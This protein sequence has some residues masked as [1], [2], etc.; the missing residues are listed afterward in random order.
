MDAHSST[1]RQ[2]GFGRTAKTAA[3]VAIFTGVT[4]LG[5][6]AGA[7]PPEPGRASCM[8]YEASAV[9]PPGTSDEAP[10]G[11]PNVLADVDEFFVSPN[12]DFRNRG[13]V[14]SFFTKLEA[15]SHEACDEALVEAVFGGA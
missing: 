11:M 4:A 14:I 1:S 3:A 10:G 12:G 8:G 13:R 7:E 5:G 9:S 2:R 15:D 6:T